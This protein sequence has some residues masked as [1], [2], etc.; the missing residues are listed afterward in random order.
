MKKYD[1]GTSEI[2]NGNILRTLIFLSFPIVINQ[3]LQTFYNISDSYFMGILG[4]DELA[5]SAFTFPIFQLLTNLGGG[6]ATGGM[7]IFSRNVGAGEFD[8]A[9]K[10]KS[11]LIFLN[12]VL[13]ILLSTLT[14]LMSKNIL[15][16]SGAEGEL[17]RLSNSYTQI[18]FFSIPWIFI[19]SSYCS[20]ENSKGNTKKPML[21]VAY[22]IILNIILNSLAVYFK[23]GI[24]GIALATFISNM[25]LAIYCISFLLKN[26]DIQLNL[27]RFNRKIAL[28]II[29]LG[30]PVALSSALANLGFVV[31]NR[32]VVLFGEDVLASFGIGN[33][34]NNIFYTPANGISTGVS[35]MI[36]Q[37][38]GAGNR[39]RIREIF[40]K[41]MK[42]T[43]IIS[44]FGS[45]GI[46]LLRENMI[47]LFTE[48]KSIIFHTNN[49]L[50][51]FLY[52]NVAW[53][54]YQ[55]FSGFF[56]GMGLT[57]LN[58]YIN[59]GRVWLFRVPIL[60]LLER[61]FTLGAYSVWFAMLI[62]NLLVMVVAWGI[63]M[64][65]YNLKQL[66]IS[67]K[68]SESA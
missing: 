19:T 8:E 64:K 59:L 12:I 35:I 54:V 6:L 66:I 31:L 2:L 44:L 40:T 33:R 58:F 25:I 39:E 67:E 36:S 3:L 60:L 57:K 34:L 7:I 45:L 17:L 27:M 9:L 22:S 48:N 63:Y 51:V 52:C 13:G 37:N 28:E 50:K 55:V 16:Y 47:T 21:L 53:G 68:I 18:L 32:H 26:G 4:S 43:V 10:S 24:T 30:I 23:L 5:A 15:S 62:S 61:F 14:F 65:N 20:I 49:F 1:T 38:F 29:N 46:Y 41:A 56:L 42:L 11:Q